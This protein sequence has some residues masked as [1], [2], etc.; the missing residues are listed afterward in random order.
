MAAPRRAAAGTSASPSPPAA[1]E[2]T[3]AVPRLYSRPRD[4]IWGPSRAWAHKRSRLRDRRAPACIRETRVDLNQ[5]YFDHQIL[6]IRA[7]G[8]AS[9]GTRRGHEREAAHVAAR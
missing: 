3:A 4:P 1:F 8:A 9:P 5:L 2:G 6:L 7:D